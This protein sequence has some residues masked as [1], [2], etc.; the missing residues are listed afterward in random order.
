MSDGVPERPGPP[1]GVGAGCGLMGA[2]RCSLLTAVDGASG[3]ELSEQSSVSDSPAK[4]AAK[5][6]KI[7][8]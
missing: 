8:K 5:Q 1:S 2:D 7:T 6:D 3:A 4:D